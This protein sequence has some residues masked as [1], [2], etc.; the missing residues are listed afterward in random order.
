[1]YVCMYVCMY[2]Y[3]KFVKFEILFKLFCSRG[4]YVIL[5]WFGCYEL[6]FKQMGNE[7]LTMKV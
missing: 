5:W 1:M 6:V 2:V 7:V 3:I 4:E